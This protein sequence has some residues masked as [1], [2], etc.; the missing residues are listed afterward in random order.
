MVRKI[1]NIK[2]MPWVLEPGARR[3][4]KESVVEVRVRKIEVWVLVVKLM[5]PLVGDNRTARETKS[6]QGKGWSSI[7]RE[8]KLPP[9]ILEIYENSGVA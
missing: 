5:L 4:R 9:N 7:F 2:Q 1:E 3:G 8:L 6:L